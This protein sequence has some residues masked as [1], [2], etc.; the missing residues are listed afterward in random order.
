[1]KNILFFLAGIFLFSNTVYAEVS[2]FVFV[3]EPQNIEVGKPSGTITVQ[4][5]N[6][7]GTSENITET[8]DITFTSTSGTGQFFSTSLN[9]V[10]T[11]MSRN[12][13]NKNFLYQ[14]STGG[15][16][17]LEIK[18]VGRTSG[19]SFSTNQ[20]IVV[21]SGGGVTGGGNNSTT[22]GNNN[23]TTTES[24]DPPPVYSAHSS[25][26]PLGSGEGKIEFEVY[27]GRDRLTS[28]GNKIVFKVTPTKLQNVSEGSAYYDWSFGDGTTGRGSTVE[29]Q[30]KFAGEYNVVVNARASD[31]E[32]VSRFTV[33]VIA[34]DFSLTRVVGGLEIKNNSKTEVNMEGWGLTSKNK[35]FVFPKD[36]LIPAGKKV[37]FADETTGIAGEKIELLNPLG[38]SFGEVALDVKKTETALQNDFQNLDIPL[39]QAKLDEAKTKLS[40]LSPKKE[41]TILT[42]RNLE[43][44]K[45]VSQTKSSLSL[46]NSTST[47]ELDE[48]RAENTATVFVAQK[49]TG[50]VSRIFSLPIKGFNLVRRLFVE[51]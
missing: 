49:Q 7:G 29:H 43:S 8:F 36:T 15:T 35:S 21:G 42:Q 14:D 47:V 10:S 1:M 44:T 17:T 25:Y 24:N 39:L 50:M 37:V 28:V 19:A 16:Y 34:P 4:S 32:A 22:T 20:Q 13:A 2:Q 41:T 3:T 18:A 40:L 5:Q 31:K 23:T 38:K 30:Y 48:T 45:E 46:F 51:D 6:S 11:T 27:G 9:P 12:T 33:S 26:V